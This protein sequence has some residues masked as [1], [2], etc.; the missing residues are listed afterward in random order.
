M[1]EEERGDWFS[2]KSV[3]SSISEE[4]LA[5]SIKATT[6]NKAKTIVSAK[7]TRK[8]KSIKK[9]KDKPKRP[10]SAYNIFFRS[11]R[12]LLVQKGRDLGSG[13]SKT[14]QM[15][16]AG[17]ARHVA[18]KWNTLDASERRPFI[19]LAIKEKVRYQAS[20]TKWKELQNRNALEEIHAPHPEEKEGDPPSLESLGLL[21]AD[22]T[23]SN[24]TPTLAFSDMMKLTSRVVEDAKM[25]LY[26]PIIQELRNSNCKGTR[27][28]FAHQEGH[29][30]LGLD[31]DAPSCIAPIQQEEQH[32]DTCEVECPPQGT[33][34]KMITEE[35]VF[36]SSIV[37]VS[38]DNFY[39]LAK[40]LAAG[41]PS[42]EEDPPRQ[43][44]FT[45][46]SAQC[47]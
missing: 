24:M 13:A 40:F 36:R 20:V 37:E 17:M 26:K 21:S 25:A 42:E 9:L 6:H 1:T 12:K 34:T 46:N 19:E 14:P 43:E 35:S 10:L 45:S 5:S 44:Y 41:C 28:L 29:Y 7:P 32:L 15:G 8:F 23:D 47:V 18:G 30:L 39:N 4:T 27:D 22:S 38:E 33:R 11:E 3:P 2:D 31:F 16:F